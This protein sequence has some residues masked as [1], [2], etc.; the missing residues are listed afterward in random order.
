MDNQKFTY[1]YYNGQ[2]IIENEP[3]LLSQ[4][5]DVFISRGSPRHDVLKYLDE[6]AT[7]CCMFDGDKCIGLAWLAFYGKK[8][9]AEICWLATNISVKGLDGKY[10]LD[11][12]LNY[13]KNKGVKSVKFNCDDD[14]WG[15]IK[16]K[17]QLFEKFGY[18]LSEEELYDMS[19]EI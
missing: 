16:N 9:I 18:K 14:S 3:E 12:V 19:I 5:K 6:D 8:H 1:K 11:E 10:L 2:Q 15:R 13:C 4:L 7:V 17:E